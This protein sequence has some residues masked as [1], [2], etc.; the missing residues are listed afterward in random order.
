MKSHTK[1][2]RFNHNPLNLILGTRKKQGLRIGY[3]EAAL[4]GF[5]L[6]CMET[7]VHP[8]KLSKLLSDKFH[9]TDAISSCQLFLFLINEGD[10]AS[11][12]IMVPYL[13]STENLNQFENTIRERFYGV[14]RFIQQG[15]NLYKFKEYIEER[16]E[17]IVWINDL[18]RG[19]IGWDIAQVVGLARA[20]KDCGYITK[21]QAWEWLIHERRVELGLESHRFRDLKRWG[22]AK[23][24]LNA[25]G[26][27]FTDRNYLF[28]I[29]QKDI[30][31]S[32]GKLIQNPGY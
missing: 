17:P 23:E 4:D 21:E 18:E 16:G 12:S 19:V 28:P 10:R 1:N 20:A 14:D 8:E 3:M 26:Q 30:D 11:Y 15:R 5:Y 13:L 7:G 24:V 32:G 27:A 9:C 29:P 2:L 22:I 25:N 6:N 31:K